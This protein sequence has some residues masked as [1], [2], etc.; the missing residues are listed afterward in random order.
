MNDNGLQSLHC[1]RVPLSLS[2]ICYLLEVRTDEF[3]GN[4]VKYAHGMMIVDS[5]TYIC[6]TS[7]T[8]SLEMSYITKKK[9]ILAM[10]TEKNKNPS[11]IV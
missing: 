11:S 7:M 5:W 6:T 3:I 9:S 2:F 10:K 1:D 4:F 8:F